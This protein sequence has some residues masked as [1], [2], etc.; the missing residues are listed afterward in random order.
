MADAGLREDLARIFLPTAV[1]IVCNVGHDSSLDGFLVDIAEE[2]GEV[3]H[4]V[5]RLGAETLLEEMAATLILAV[6]FVFLLRTSG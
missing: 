5:D 1:G 3:V 6:D 4:I 2:G